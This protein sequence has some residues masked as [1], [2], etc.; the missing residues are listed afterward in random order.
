MSL[1]LLLALAGCLLFAGVAVVAVVLVVV[2]SRPRPRSYDLAYRPTFSAPLERVQA[3]A[4]ELTAAEWEE[5]RRWVAAR[6]TP[7][8]PPSEAITR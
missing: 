6:Q 7:P 3:A 2:L 1:M 8:P 5:F 4:S